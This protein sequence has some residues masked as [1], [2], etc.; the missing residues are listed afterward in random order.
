[1]GRGGGRSRLR[2]V[3]K[4]LQDRLGGALQRGRLLSGVITAVVWSFSRGRAATQCRPRLG[5]S[6]WVPPLCISLGRVVE[7]L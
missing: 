6:L 1:M 2:P 3:R 5:S 4:R 7:V